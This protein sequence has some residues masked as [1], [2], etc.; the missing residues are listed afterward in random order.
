VREI[1]PHFLGAVSA[2]LKFADAQ[3]KEQWVGE[4]IRELAD[5]PN[6]RTNID[7]QDHPMAHLGRIINGNPGDDLEYAGPCF[8]LTI[9][10]V[11]EGLACPLIM[12]EWNLNDSQ[13]R[14]MLFMALVVSC[15]GSIATT[16]F[17]ARRGSGGNLNEELRRVFRRKTSR[18]E[19]R[20]QLANLVLAGQVLSWGHRVD[21]V[22]EANAQETPDWQVRLATLPQN[23]P[24][25]WVECTSVGR[26]PFSQMNDTAAL[27]KAVAR[28]WHEKKG[29]F[30]GGFRPGIIVL[31]MS[32]IFVNPARACLS[33]PGAQAR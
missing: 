16:I 32:A 25:L 31:D 19:L 7:H 12:A 21:F 27:R 1:D 22:A 26:P 23:G 9:G 24:Q 30:H 28:A 15:L 3:S 8:L 14:A 4:I 20:G 33:P 13:P 5:L 18:E 17:W 6:W 10:E 11:I 29:K 2:C